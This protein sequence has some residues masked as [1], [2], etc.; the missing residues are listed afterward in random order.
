MEADKIMI[1]IVRM[2]FFTFLFVVILLTGYLM[3]LDL[4]KDF[5]KMREKENILKN[6]NKKDTGQTRDIKKFKV[7]K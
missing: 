5:K 7:I 1:Q 2:I 4:R 6:N 3:L